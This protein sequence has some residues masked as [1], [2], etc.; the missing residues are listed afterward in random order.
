MSQTLKYYELRTRRE[1]ALLPF[2]AGRRD[3]SE[4]VFIVCYEESYLCLQIA[5]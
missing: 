4:P 3:I 2:I 1:L 5:L